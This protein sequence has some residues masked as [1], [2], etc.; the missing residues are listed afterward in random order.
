MALSPDFRWKVPEFSGT[1]AQANSMAQGL[2]SLA[3]GIGSAIK[4]AYLR[5]EQQRRND[6]EDEDRRRRIDEE[7]R[8]IAAY[9]DVADIMRNRQSKLDSLAQE[10][11]QI[12]KQIQQLQQE[13][14]VQ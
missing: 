7:D 13:L 14:G 2:S 11:S 5:K 3:T 8:R 9:R 4:G 1:S 12:V 6:I 10:R